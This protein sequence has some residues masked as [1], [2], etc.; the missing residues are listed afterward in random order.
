MAFKGAEMK[1]LVTGSAGFIASHLIPKLDLKYDVI[2][3]DIK[4]IG[5]VR[6]QEQCHDFVNEIDV[7]IHLAALVDVQESIRIPKHYHDTNVGGTLNLLSAAEFFKVKRFIYISS[8]AADNPTS[9]YGIQKLTSEKYC[10]FYHKQYG[11][12]VIT[13]RLF[14]VYG[15]GN[16]KGVIDKW[17]NAVRRNERPVIYGGRQVRDFIYVEDV[18]DSICSQIEST[19]TGVKDS[20]TGI[21]T[22]MLDLCNIIL[23]IM[24][25]TDLKPIVKPQQTGEIQESIGRPCA[26]SYSLRDGLKRCIDGYSAH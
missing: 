12:S 1:I 26:C 23:R 16:G 13:L 21:G 9:P 3:M 7:I 8:A 6:S 11:L 17:I 18:V 14:N 20:A 19:E 4:G 24:K 25:K 2:P 22:D 5:D 15:S 10:D